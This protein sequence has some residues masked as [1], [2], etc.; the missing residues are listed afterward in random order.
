[1]KP[2]VTVKGGVKGETLLP[3]IPTAIPITPEGDD[4]A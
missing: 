3:I 1:M 2:N 4:N